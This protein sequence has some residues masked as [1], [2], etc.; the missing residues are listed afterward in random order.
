MGERERDSER[1]RER[2]CEREGEGEKNQV[3]VFHAC[4]RFRLQTFPLISQDR[5][6]DI[7]C[8]RKKN[9]C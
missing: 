7:Y 5:R 1:G 8:H 3:I 6:L 4:L 2:E 9:I